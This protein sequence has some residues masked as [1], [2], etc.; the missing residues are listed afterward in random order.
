MDG[1]IILDRAPTMVLLF[2]LTAPEFPRDA[3]REIRVEFCL[4]LRRR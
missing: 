1:T 3:C 4:V 2:P